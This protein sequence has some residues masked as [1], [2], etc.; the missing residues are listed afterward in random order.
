MQF[1]HGLDSFRGTRA[2]DS[3]SLGEV[4]G[5]TVKVHWTDQPYQWHVNDGAEAFVVLAGTVDMHWRNASGEHVTRLNAGDAC[6][7]NTGDE[8]VAHPQGAARILVVEKK[9]SV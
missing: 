2:W 8:H 1:H 9:G 6:F 4:E 3:T 7:A 5:A